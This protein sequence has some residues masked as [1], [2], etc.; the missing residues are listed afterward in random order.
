[1][2]A[3]SSISTRFVVPTTSTRL[4]LPSLDPAKELSDLLDRCPPCSWFRSDRNDFIS[5]MTTTAGACFAAVS[6]SSPTFRAVSWMY[7]A[8]H[9]PCF[10]G[11]ERPVEVLDEAPDREALPA[12]GGPWRTNEAGNSIPNAR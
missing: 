1:M 6:K 3:S 12:P 5:S 7:G 10:D 11:E 8:P 2:M 9:G 4:R